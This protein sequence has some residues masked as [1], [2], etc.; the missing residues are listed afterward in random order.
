LCRLLCNYL[1]SR[2]WWSPLGQF[3]INDWWF[4]AFVSAFRFS[5]AHTF[6]FLL[7]LS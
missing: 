1:H 2:H 6:F 4:V 3:A 7:P 5:F